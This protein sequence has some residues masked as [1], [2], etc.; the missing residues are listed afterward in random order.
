MRF[1]GAERLIRC[2]VSVESCD[3]VEL[4]MQGMKDS[5]V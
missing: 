1:F 3:E 4:L 5:F 2:N